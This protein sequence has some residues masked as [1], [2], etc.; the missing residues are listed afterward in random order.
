MIDL[1]ILS[2]IIQLRDD[3]IAWATANFNM[4]VPTSRTI[5]GKE[6][7]NNIT[8]VVSDIDQA[9][10]SSDID[11]VQGTLDTHKS[12]NTM[13][14]TS[15]ERT[16]WDTAYSQSHTHNNKSVID[17]VTSALVT[18]WNS[19]KTHADSA[20]APSDAEPNQNA[21]GNVLVG[22]TTIASDS[23]SDTLTF[24]AGDN[25]TLTPDATN[26]KI[27]ISSKDTT[28]STA[29]TSAD[30]LMSASDKTKIEGMVVST[31]SEVKTYLG[32]S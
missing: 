12:D 4:K 25:V 19:A 5:N 2:A 10:S 3:I 7:S 26:D 28:Y 22:S 16:N 31:L 29:T 23:T 9:A 13:H 8:L 11:S 15:T 32:I 17:G 18:A 1:D 6:L 14:I 20:H 21:F 30:G 27:T 24:A